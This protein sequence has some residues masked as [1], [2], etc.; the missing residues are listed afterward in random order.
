MKV[1]IKV[2]QYDFRGEFRPLTKYLNNLGIVYRL[3]CS[4]TSRQNG[5]VERKHRSIVEMGLTLLAYAHIPPDYWD[6]SFTHAVYL[7]N[8]FPSSNFPDFTSPFHA[9]F[10]I[11]PDY[12]CL[13]TFGCLCFP[14]LRPFNKNKLQ[15]RSDACIYLGVSPHHKGHKCLSKEGRIYI[16]KNVVFDETQFP[17]NSI[18]GNITQQ[19]YGFFPSLCKRFILFTAQ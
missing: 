5:T 13:G 1:P 18:L 14:H 10:N 11:I 19:E 7:L 2:V 12:K 9:L 15:F 8:R 4:H 17:Y 16:S 6:H 3:T